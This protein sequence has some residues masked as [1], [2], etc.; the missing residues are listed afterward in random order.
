MNGPDLKRWREKVAELPA[1]AFAAM[2]NLSPY[3]LKQLEAS[4]DAVPPHI[5]NFTLTYE[6]AA[7]EP[8]AA[9]PESE[10]IAAAVKLADAYIAGVENLAAKF[11]PNCPTQWAASYWYEGAMIAPAIYYG[12]QGVE[13]CHPARQAAEARLTAFYDAG[14][15][16]RGLAQ[17]ADCPA[18]IKLKAAHAAPA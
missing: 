4:A 16:W 11:G 14:G 3:R 17:L 10:L 2:V 12:P 5:V 13:P 9:R 15:L 8:H 1:A 6:P 18:A 7:E